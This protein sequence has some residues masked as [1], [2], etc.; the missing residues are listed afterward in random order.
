VTEPVPQPAPP[1]PQPARKR[2]KI[3]PESGGKLEQLLISNKKADDAESVAK[4]AHE[5]L[6][7]A[8][9]AWLLSVFPDPADLPDAFDI[10]ADPHGR[11]PA[12]TM[13]LK[14]GWRVDSKTMAAEDPETYQRWLKPVKASWEL[15]ENKGG[16]RRG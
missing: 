3:E 11:Y 12:Y 15:R 7:A 6:K 16:A 14:G 10:T 5:E 8:I 1:V 2:A 9:K 13:T 4:E